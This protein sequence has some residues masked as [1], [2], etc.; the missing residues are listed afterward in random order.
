MKVGGCNSYR[1]SYMSKDK[2][3]K[4]FAWS[5][6]GQFVFL[7][8]IIYYGTEGVVVT[9]YWKT[10]FVLVC[11]RLLRFRR[12]CV[13]LFSSLDMVYLRSVFSLIL[14][15]SSLDIDVFLYS[16]ELME[17]NVSWIKPLCPWPIQLTCDNRQGRAPALLD[18]L[19]QAFL[20]A[21]YFVLLEVL[22]HIAMHWI[23]LCYSISCLRNRIEVGEDLE[24]ENQHTTTLQGF[25]PLLPIRSDA[26][27]TF[28]L[29]RPS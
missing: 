3:N 15:T 6:L 29:L 12:S 13:G 7:K 27:K 5:N 23:Y 28:A 9:D 14:D 22:F 4:W 11:C 8:S 20:M 24:E 16:N 17:I 21:P 1:V 26:L 25:F 10:Y 2:L 18:N 19:A